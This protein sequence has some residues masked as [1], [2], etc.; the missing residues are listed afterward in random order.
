MINCYSAD[1]TVFCPNCW[2]NL[3][4]SWIDVKTESG[5]VLY[6]CWNCGQAFE[7]DYKNNV[8]KKIGESRR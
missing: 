1:G 7:I 5:K 8:I 6:K 2:S 4:I 3:K